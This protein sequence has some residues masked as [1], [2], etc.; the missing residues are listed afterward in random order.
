MIGHSLPRPAIRLIRR[1]IVIGALLLTAPAIAQPTDGIDPE[2]WTAQPDGAVTHKPTGAV[3]PAAYGI[4]KRSR[5]VTIAPDGSDIAINYDAEDGATRTRLSVFLFRPHEGERGLKGALAAI[6]ARSPE[7]FVWA[8]GPFTIPAPQSA[9]VPLRAF[10]GVYKTGEG[11]NAVMDYLYLAELGSWSVKVR[12]TIAQVNDPSQEEAIDLVVRDLPWAAI[13]KANGACSG[14]ACRTGGAVQFDSHM[15]ESLLPN[16][17]LKTTK[18]D[19]AAERDLPVVGGVATPPLG[20]AAVQRSTRDPVVYVAE[21]KGLGT[22][23]MVKLPDMLQRMVGGAFGKLSV[24]GPIYAV[25]IDSGG[26]VLMPRFFAGGEP[27]PA[28]FGAVVSELV[29]H[30]TASPFVT[31]KETAAAIPAGE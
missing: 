26:N 15:A 18:F 31:V 1:I 6:A 9:P 8:D 27:T 24:D 21:V 20:D 25:A 2:V 23:R 7:A 19:P 4:F 14:A 28:Q 3:F 11:P 5:I 17:L 12:A 16:L 10:K 22:F 13:L 30:S 29:L